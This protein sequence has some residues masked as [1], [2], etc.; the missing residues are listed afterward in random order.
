MGSQSKAR[1]RD[2]RRES[3][4][5]QMQ[6]VEPKKSPDDEAAKRAGAV[7]TKGIVLRDDKARKHKKEIYEQPAV[8]DKRQ[9]TDVADPTRME[10]RHQDRAQPPQRIEIV[11]VAVLL[12]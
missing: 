6:R 7:D 12:H 9:Q 4:S 10:Q 3:K 2:G 5:Q 11:K 1:N 8:R